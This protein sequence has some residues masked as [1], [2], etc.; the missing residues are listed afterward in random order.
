M[1][2]SDLAVFSEYLYTTM[3]EVVAQQ[4]DLFNAA[5][6]GTI[7]LSAAAHQGD[8]NE[9]AFFGKIA[10]LVRRRDAYGSGAVAQ[11]TLAQIVD[12]MVKVASGTPPIRLDPG[13]F[14]WIQMNPETAGAALGQ[15][16]AKD[17]LADMLN[18]GSAACYAALSGQA[19]DIQYDGTGATP[20]TFNPAMTVEGA[21]KMGDRSSEIVAWLVH[22]YAMTK[23][24]GTAIANTTN[25]FTYGTVN[26]LSDPFGRVFVVSDIPALFASGSP[27]LAYSLGLTPGAITIDQN[28][29]YTEN[30]QTT[31][32]DE[33][34]QRTFQS[35]WSYNLGIKGFSWDKANGGKSPNDAALTTATNWDKIVT[36]YKDLAGV[37]VKSN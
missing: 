33:N 19:S 3:T 11:K 4:V 20:D 5:S 23:Y 6:R 32:G 2:L 9:K 12:T 16:L 35:E 10:G 25:L 28:N 1:A 7:T 24:W 18:I 31:N 29:D 13:Q 14:K 15:Q 34:I 37:I 21:G 8:F 27:N 26:V 30:L 17:M 36:S 22:S